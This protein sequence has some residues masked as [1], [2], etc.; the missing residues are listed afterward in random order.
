MDFLSRLVQFPSESIMSIVYCDLYA[1]ASDKSIQDSYG[2]GHSA[3]DMTYHQL[4]SELSEKPVFLSVI[5][6]HSLS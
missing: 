5:T 4:H 3:Y 1:A 2:K 6:I